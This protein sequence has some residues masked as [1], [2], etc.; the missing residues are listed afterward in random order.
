MFI[1]FLSLDFSYHHWKDLIDISGIGIFTE[2]NFTTTQD[3]GIIKRGLFQF[4]HFNEL[5]RDRLNLKGFLM[6][7][8]LDDKVEICM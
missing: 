5:W 1:V 3:F 2:S 6:V 8:V 4:G 7:C